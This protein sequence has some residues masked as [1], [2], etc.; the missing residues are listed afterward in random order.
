MGFILH[1]QTALE[2]A[3]VSISK[4]D[5][6][7]AERTS[8]SQ[9][10][11]ASFLHQAIQEMLSSSGIGINDLSAV[12]VVSGPGSYTGLRVGMSCAKGLC[13]ALGLPLITVNT[14]EW[15]AEAA[16]GPGHGLY[17]PM[18]DARRMEVFTALYAA[19][20]TPIVH[21]SAIL[22]EP[23]SFNKWIGENQIVF[24]GNGSGKFKDMIDHPNAIFSEFA[25]GSREMIGVARTRFETREFAGLT[26]SEPSYL[27]EFHSTK[28]V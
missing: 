13:F 1:I 10:D 23:D 19:D 22:L 18:I 28:P 2:T 25:P 17:C 3:F 9:K 15:M 12:S 6:L 24:F 5:D 20:R 27:K 21:P 16:Y 11:H 7:I 26:E 4:E 8:V 14:L